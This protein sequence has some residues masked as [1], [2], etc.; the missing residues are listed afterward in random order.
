MQIEPLRVPILLT[1]AFPVI[2]EIGGVWKLTGLG[3]DEAK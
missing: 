3:C 1:S 2:G